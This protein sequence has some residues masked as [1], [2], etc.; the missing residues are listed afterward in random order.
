MLNP[1][2]II[3]LILMAVDNLIHFMSYAPFIFMLL[4]KILRIIQ[5]TNANNGTKSSIPYA[6]IIWRGEADVSIIFGT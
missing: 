1:K 6:S 3:I 5:T 4:L 2:A